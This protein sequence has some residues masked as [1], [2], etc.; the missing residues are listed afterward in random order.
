[1][2]D[3]HHGTGQQLAQQIRIAFARWNPAGC[4]VLGHCL[5]GISFNDEQAGRGHRFPF[6]VR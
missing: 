6:Q 1:M 4:D 2:A 5:R 3:I